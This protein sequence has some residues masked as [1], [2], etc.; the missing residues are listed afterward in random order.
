[1]RFAFVLNFSNLNLRFLFW[2]WGSWIDEHTVE[3]HSDLSSLILKLDSFTCFC[4]SWE[5]LLLLVDGAVS[6]REFHFLCSR[7]LHDFDLSNPALENAVCVLFCVNLSPISNLDV[8]YKYSRSFSFD[9]SS[10]S[11]VFLLCTAER[12]SYD[13]VLP[14]ETAK[15][16]RLPWPLK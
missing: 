4:I 14:G 12:W 1:M 6:M 5:C 15:S 7:A 3:E 16:S 11:S 10:P 2:I 9:Q 8:R 13:F